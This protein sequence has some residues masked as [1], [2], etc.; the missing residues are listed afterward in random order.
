MKEESIL[1]SALAVTSIVLS[2]AD[3]VFVHQRRVM[4]Q[5]YHLRNGMFSRA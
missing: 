5:K 2:K 1:T 4:E 3:R